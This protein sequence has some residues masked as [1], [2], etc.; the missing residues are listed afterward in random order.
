MAFRLDN[1][2]GYDTEDLR[3]FFERGLAATGTPQRGL[4][5]VVF[6]APQR[7]RGCA[8][9]GGKRMTIAIAPPSHFSLRRFGCLFRH[10][11][12]HIRG[13]EHEEMPKRVL[14]SLGPVPWWAEGAEIRYR[15]RAPDQ[16]E[17]LHEDRMTRR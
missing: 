16:M 3:A 9:V 4:T 8:D 12:A 5:I 14:L 1:R 6:A 10:E 11:A 15:G 17:F 7:S 13:Y 2:S